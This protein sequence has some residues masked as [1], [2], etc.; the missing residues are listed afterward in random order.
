MKVGWID[1]DTFVTVGIKHFKQWSMKGSKL[2]KKQ[3]SVKKCFVSLAIG[4]GLVLTG[5]ERN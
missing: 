4:D 5:S 1:E 2:S 3:S